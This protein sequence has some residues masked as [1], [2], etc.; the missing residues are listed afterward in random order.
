MPNL[1]RKQLRVPWNKASPKRE[2]RSDERYHT[3]RW[4][5][6]SRWYRKTFPVCRECGNAAEVVDHIIPARQ[7]EAERF[8]DVTNM[9]PLCSRCHNR[10]RATDDKQ[11]PK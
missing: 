2:R 8:Y 4:T 3:H 7:I 10:K 11:W 1:P 9:Q 6:F 5:K